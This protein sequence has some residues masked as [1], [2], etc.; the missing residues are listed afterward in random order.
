M[1]HAEH[2]LFIFNFEMPIKIS[3]G[4]IHQYNCSEK[5]DIIC[6]LTRLTSVRTCFMKIRK[7]DHR[8]HK[9]SLPAQITIKNGLEFKMCLQQNLKMIKGNQDQDNQYAP[10][11]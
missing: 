5:L 11:K 7:Q 9:N 6:N 4:E 1:K 3:P 8:D 10:L 2:G